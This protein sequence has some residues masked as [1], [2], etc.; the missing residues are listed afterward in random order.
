LRDQF[1]YRVLAANC[2]RVSNL[3]EPT[4]RK[5]LASISAAPERLDAWR[6]WG[7]M[8]GPG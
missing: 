2:S 7:E 8:L 6:R 1:G 4:L 3:E 5:A